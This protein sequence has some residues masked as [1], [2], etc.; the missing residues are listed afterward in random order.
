MMTKSPE[1]SPLRAVRSSG[2]ADSSKQALKIEPPISGPLFKSVI[3]KKLKAA[4]KP[5]L[6]PTKLTFSSSLSSAKTLVSSNL[7]PISKK[8]ATELL[9]SKATKHNLSKKTV[10]D[11]SLTKSD[12][13]TL[14]KKR[15]L[16]D[17]KLVKKK[18]Q[19][20]VEPALRRV[21]SQG[22]GSGAGSNLSMKK[23]HS[24]TVKIAGSTTVKS[25]SISSASVKPKSLP[26]TTVNSTIKAEAHT[27]TAAATS[28]ATVTPLSKVSDSILNIVKRPRGRPPKSQQHKNTIALIASGIGKE[29]KNSSTALKPSTSSTTKEPTPTPATSIT[30]TRSTVKKEHTPPSHS[31]THSQ[32]QHAHQPH[33]TKESKTRKE[34]RE[35]QQLTT[36]DLLT[37]LEPLTSQNKL[38]EVQKVLINHLAYS[39]NQQTPLT[40]LLV[41]K[42]I[43]ENKITQYQA[44]CVL[45]LCGCINV[46]ERS[47]KDAAGKPLDEQYYYIPEDDDD[48]ERARLV[49]E[50]KGSA[51]HLRSCRKTHKQY[52]WKKPKK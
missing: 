18:S 9:F 44:R 37:I 14:L 4:S 40:D 28:T 49:V 43:Q 52:Y 22:C 23:A 29:N 3:S 8:A 11:F 24:S 34:F 31:H 16:D 42:A 46:I 38:E 13:H 6:K 51:S 27:T 35:I 21:K 30:T 10:S 26:T 36:P 39:R 1:T 50:L 12:K 47:G 25:K 17:L 33:E 7:K 41:L 5:Q 19:S 45:K 15:S 32:H 48:K 20:P 2:K